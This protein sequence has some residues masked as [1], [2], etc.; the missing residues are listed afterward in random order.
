[1]NMNT[2]VT[3]CLYVCGAVPYCGASHR[4]ASTFVEPY[5]SMVPIFVRKKELEQISGVLCSEFGF[6]FEHSLV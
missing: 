2:H 1:M 3:V 5:P 6:N 4:S